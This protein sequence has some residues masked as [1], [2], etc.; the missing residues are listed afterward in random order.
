MGALRLTYTKNYRPL[1][2]MRGNFYLQK[3]SDAE[4]YQVGFNGQLKDNEIYGEGNAY[5][6]E[7]WEYDPRSIRRWNR[8]PVV[9]PWESPYAAFSN[10]PI[11]F[12]D[13]KGD[14]VGVPSGLFDQSPTGPYMEGY[15]QE[16]MSMTDWNTFKEGIYEV[17]G[18]S[19]N[20]PSRNDQYLTIGS[21]DESVGS[22]L[23]RTYVSKILAS[24]KNHQK[25]IISNNNPDILGGMNNTV[26]TFDPNGII[27]GTIY[28]AGV[29]M[30]D[31]QD[32]RDWKAFN[33]GIKNQSDSRI[34]SVGFIVIHENLHNWGIGKIGT[35]LEAQDNE[36]VVIGRVNEMRV[37]MNLPRRLS[38]SR[39]KDN[40]GFE[41]LK[42]EN[43]QRFYIEKD[44]NKFNKEMQKTLPNFNK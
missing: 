32:I 12:I 19:L 39:E 44:F 21:V 41:Y 23:A 7:F 37:Q 13:V 26:F 34:M 20:T 28:N 18:I 31:L 40:L 38:H 15:N 24:K 11:V 1:K 27:D 33:K 5:T 17:S 25:I 4:R 35:K 14:S 8:D 22:P 3:N 42:F 9:K 10:N 30:L 16:G 29:L 43:N 36:D 2:V 6:A